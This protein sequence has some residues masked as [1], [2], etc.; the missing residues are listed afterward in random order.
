M[1]VPAPGLVRYGEATLSDVLPSVLSTFGADEPNPLGLSAAP[2]YVVLLI[3]GL[4]WN[5]LRA[6][7]D[8]A[9]FLNRLAG[10]S[11]TAGFP[12]TTAASISSLGTGLPSGVH[13]IT[14]YTTALPGVSEAINWLTWQ[15]A[16]SG[17]D[18][19]P[20]Q[21]PEQVQPHPTGF[22]RAAAAGVA[23]SVVSFHAYEK[24]GLTRAV[25]RGATYRPTFTAAD[26][27]VEV[28]RAARQG[29]ITYCYLSELDLIGHGSGCGSEAWRL[30]LALI[31]RA[32]ELLARQLPAEARLLVTADHGMV[33]VPA[34]D[35]IDH[36]TE[37]VLR[38]HVALVA[39]EGRARY[40][41]L[42]ADEHRDEVR[43]NWIDRLG[44]EFAVLTR[45]EVIDLGW[46][47]PEVTAPARSRIGDLVVL[48]LGSGAVIRSKAEPLLS[49]LP[50]QHGSITEDELLVPLL[51]L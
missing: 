42:T 18:L 41:Y 30:Q 6:H 9:R 25:L 45:D 28:G 43:Q 32:V 27:A 46:Y 35:R 4:G 36:D 51:Q 1:S 7:P 48:A 2:A 14:G 13:G 17:T 33:D 40:L 8:Q 15:G 16:S 44:P 29:G 24:S 31:D 20:S 26:L 47:G 23:V 22:E 12:T 11:L 49:R 50:G 19:L 37:A 5:L 34:T 10:R 3:D 39:G 38:E 21:P